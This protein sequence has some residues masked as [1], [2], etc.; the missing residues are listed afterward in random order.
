MYGQLEDAYIKTFQFFGY[1]DMLWMQIGQSIDL[2]DMLHLQNLEVDIF[3]LIQV[4]KD[5]CPNFPFI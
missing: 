5:Q 1:W 2:H 3:T 4:I